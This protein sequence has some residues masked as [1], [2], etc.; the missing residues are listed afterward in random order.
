MLYSEGNFILLHQH[1]KRIAIALSVL[2]RPCLA[3]TSD[4]RGVTTVLERSRCSMA[5][6]SLVVTWRNEATEPID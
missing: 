5:A 3:D 1:A 2:K 4:P 6:H